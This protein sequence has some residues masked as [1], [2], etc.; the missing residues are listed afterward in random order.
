ML[1][2]RELAPLVHRAIDEGRIPEWMARHDEFE[3]DLADAEQRPADIARFEE[4][5]LG[6]IEDVVDALAWTEYDDA[7]GQFADEDFDAEWTPTEPV[8]NPLRHVGRNDPCPCG[9][10]KKYKKCCLGNRA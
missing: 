4:A 8:R 3:Q 10:G 9:S 1:G 2:L 7:M 5:H 6:Y